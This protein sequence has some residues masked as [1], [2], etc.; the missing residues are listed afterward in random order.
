[1]LRMEEDTQA[2]QALSSDEA[3]FMLTGKPAG[4]D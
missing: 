1:V 4:V 3:Q 2:Y